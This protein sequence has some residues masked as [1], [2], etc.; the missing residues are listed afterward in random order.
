MPVKTQVICTSNKPAS[1][2][3]PGVYKQVKHC[4]W[5]IPYNQFLSLFSSFHGPSRG[6]NFESVTSGHQVQLTFAQYN[7]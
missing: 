7:Q 5:Q 1:A 2:P 3:G 6:F 4:E